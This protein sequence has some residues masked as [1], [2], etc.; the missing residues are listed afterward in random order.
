M[1]SRGVGVTVQEEVAGD[2]CIMVPVNGGKQVLSGPS[3]R[4]SRGHHVLIGCPVG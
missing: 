1:R 4:R 2:K 3:P